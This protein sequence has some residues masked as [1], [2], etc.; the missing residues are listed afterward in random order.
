MHCRRF[1]VHKLLIIQGSIPF[2][3]TLESELNDHFE[4]TSVISVPE[5][6]DLLKTGQFSVVL[7][8]ESLPAPEVLSFIHKTIDPHLPVIVLAG[9]AHPEKAIT[10]MCDGAYDVIINDL[11]ATHLVAKIMKALERRDLEIRLKTLQSGFIEQNN[12]F[13]FASDTMKAVN[14]E[15]VRLAQLDFDVLLVGET[16]VGKDLL[17]AQLH[18]R[19][20]RRDK[21]FVPI[22]MR[23]LSQSLIESELFG[24]ERG[25]FSGAERSKMG[26]FE[27]ANGGTIY[28]PEVSCLDEAIQLKLQYFMQYKRISRVGQDPRRGELKLNVRLVMATNESLEHLVDTG[29]MR[30]DFYHRIAGVRLN[31]PPLRERVEDI[32]LLAEYFLETY[33]G[34]KRGE[35]HTFAPETLSLLRQHSWPGNVRELENAVKNAIAYADGPILETR[36]FPF[37]ASN[38]LPHQCPL[39][40]G[41]SGA[42][43]GYKDAELGFK[44]EYFKRLWALSGHNVTRAAALAHVTPQGMR[45]ILNSFSLK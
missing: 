32:G 25:A 1:L 33:G 44:R 42:I 16:G 34:V 6:F 11:D 38:P 19:S 28:I 24:H 41:E 29:K 40:D 14:L 9:R 45:K 39:A 10:A 17:A 37:L 12:R 5:G 4:L 22:S 21:P 35:E 8:G 7:L 30:E 31:I 23:T 15:L 27:A 13:V 36:H 3:A 18:L 20:Q 2:A 43:P 26:K